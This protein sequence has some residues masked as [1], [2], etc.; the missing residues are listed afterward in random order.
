MFSLVTAGILL[1]LALLILA[2]PPLER[3]IDWMIMP[4]K[5]G[6]RHTHLGN[7]HHNHRQ[8]RQGAGA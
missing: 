2:G 3:F 7:R 4:R 5:R 1:F 6:S 8:G